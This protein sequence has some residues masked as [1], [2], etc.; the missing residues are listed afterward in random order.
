MSDIDPTTAQMIT[1]AVS[2]DAKPDADSVSYALLDARFRSFEITMRL[3]EV[4]AGVRKVRATFT[5]P[6]LDFA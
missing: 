1:A 2:R 4:I 3:D 6:T 5:V